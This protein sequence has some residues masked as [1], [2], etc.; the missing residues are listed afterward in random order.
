MTDCKGASGFRPCF[1]CAYC[2]SKDHSGLIRFFT[3]SQH[4]ASLFEPAMDQTIKE[5]LQYLQ[6][7]S[8]IS[9]ARLQETQTLSGWNW[10]PEACAWNEELWTLIPPSWIQFDAMHVYYSNG[11][12]CEEIG[13]FYSALSSKTTL[14]RVQL[15]TF[16]LYDVSAVLATTYLL[17]FKPNSRSCP[18]QKSEAKPKANLQTGN[19]L[20]TGPTRVQRRGFCKP[21]RSTKHE[22]CCGNKM[23]VSKKGKPPKDKDITSQTMCFDVACI[24]ASPKK[25]RP[26]SRLFQAV[27]RVAVWVG[28]KN[29]L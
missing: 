1:R 7:Q 22:T 12:V 18:T 15:Q 6:Q 20:P 16:L 23:W 14:S 5:T 11:V 29:H 10:N 26:P 24:P 27:V 28:M 13:L 17:S 8:M 2:V 4:D 9:Q 3:I 21:S 25:T 19:R